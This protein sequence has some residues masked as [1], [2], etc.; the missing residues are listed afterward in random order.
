VPQ[1]IR[2]TPENH[3]LAE[4]MRFSMKPA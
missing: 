1:W 3:N 4:P 2:P